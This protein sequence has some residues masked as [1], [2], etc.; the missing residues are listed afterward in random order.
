[1]KRDIKDN[2]ELMNLLILLSALNTVPS[3][4]PADKLEDFR[5]KFAEAFG[6]PP[7]PDA[8]AAEALE[9]IKVEGLTAMDVALRDALFGPEPGGELPTHVKQFCR[10]VMNGERQALI[11]RQQREDGSSLLRAYRPTNDGL[12]LNEMAFEYSAN[13]LEQS[14][15]E[16]HSITGDDIGLCFRTRGL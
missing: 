14:W 2:H 3:S 8:V 16:F 1:M 11:I 6:A 15:A 10:I 7:V 13:E 5:T 9:S 12:E 4:K